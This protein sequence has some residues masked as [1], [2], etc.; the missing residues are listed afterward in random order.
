[1]L[2]YTSI[3]HVYTKMGLELNPPKIAAGPRRA[4]I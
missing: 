4:Q 1:M 2:I 3:H